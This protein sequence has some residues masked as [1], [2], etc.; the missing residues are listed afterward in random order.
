MKSPSK[1]S[2]IVLA[3]TFAGLA[4]A[5]AGQS[6]QKPTQPAGG[7]SAT[8]ISGAPGGAGTPTPRIYGNPAL[9]ATPGL[10]GTPGYRGTPGMEVTPDYRSTPGMGDTPSYRSTPRGD[11]TPRSSA[12]PAP[13]RTPPPGT[14]PMR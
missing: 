4:G 3:V 2:A 1:Y 6:T 13:R 7:Y 12:T 8:P 9:Q 11:T 5:A 14:T 10:Q